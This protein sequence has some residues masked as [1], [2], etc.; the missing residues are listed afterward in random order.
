M[1]LW[2]GRIE[3]II[4]SFS[5]IYC[6]LPDTRLSK[7]HSYKILPHKTTYMMLFLSRFQLEIHFEVHH[8]GFQ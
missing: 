3:F 5:V 1:Q 4:V 8:L 7:I 6:L 2:R